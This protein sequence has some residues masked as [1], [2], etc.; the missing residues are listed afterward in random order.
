MIGSKNDK[1]V[2]LNFGAPS[3]DVKEDDGE[4]NRTLLA[5]NFKVT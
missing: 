5:V 2:G 3:N 1:K 4:V